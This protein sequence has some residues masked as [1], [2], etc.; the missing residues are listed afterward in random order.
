M[1]SEYR[2][3]Q[4]RL[5]G[6]GKN[7][8][9]LSRQKKKSSICSDGR[10]SFEIKEASNPPAS[11]DVLAQSFNDPPP[12]N[13]KSD[14]VQPKGKRPRSPRLVSVDQPQ[15]KRMRPVAAGRMDDISEDELN[16]VNSQDK[17]SA[18]KNSNFSNIGS[19]QYTSRADIKKTNFRSG[20]SSRGQ[21]PDL[22]VL[23]LYR[24]VSGKFTYKEK[25][26]SLIVLDKDDKE[27]DRL[28][29]KSTVGNQTE[30]YPW[31]QIDQNKVHSVQHL[32]THSP[33]VIIHRSEIANS[34]SQLCLQFS[35]AK[36]AMDFI[37]WF[38]HSGTISFQAST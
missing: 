34:P 28:V 9:R 35:S 6:S 21:Q 11:P 7:R 29:P 3:S 27:A 10:S 32:A 13:I 38:K 19:R 12:A 2:Q 15:C 17:H 23:H 22:P 24:A 4:A 26:Q 16:Q 1:V 5:G 20:K 25:D 31:L 30:K 36:D 8:K 37:T 18:N 14:V 33:I